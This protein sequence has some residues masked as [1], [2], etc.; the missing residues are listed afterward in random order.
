VRVVTG[1]PPLPMNPAGAVPIGAAAAL[2]EGPAGGQVFVHGVLT[3]VWAPGDQAGRSLAAVQLVATGAAS[4]VEV[5]VAFDVS[6]E[7]LRR[8]ALAVS[9]AGIAALVPAKRGPKG[10]SKLTDQLVARIQGLRRD[11]A[12][13]VAIADQ[14]GVST[15]T[16]RRAI[17]APPAPVTEGGQA[18]P[19]TVGQPTVD[20][21][22]V[23]PVL[24]APAPRSVERAAAWAGWLT[25]A[26]P[27]FTACSR[28][29]LAGLFLAFPGVETTGLLDCATRVYGALPDGFYGLESMLVEGVL[30]NLVGEPRAEGASRIN[31]VDLGRV[32]GL[33]R[34]PEVKTIRRRIGQLA[35][36][37]LSADLQQAIAAHHLQTY[38]PEDQVGV[39]LYVDGHVRAYCG[40][41]AI[42]KTHAPRLKFPAPATVET[43][44]CDGAGDPVLVVMAEPSASLAGELRRLLPALREAVGDDRRVLVGFDRGGWS[45]A[46][47]EHMHTAGF[48]VLTW[49][50]GAT[51]DIAGHLFTTVTHTDP[52]TGITGTWTAAD[53]TVD[54]PINDTHRVLPMRQITKLSATRDGVRQAH[55][56]TTRTD[57]PTGEVIHRMGARW[58]VEN[59]FRYARQHFDLDSHDSY[60]ATDDDPGRLVPN[61]TRRKAHARLVAARDVVQV[62]QA[63]A[64]TALL[65]LHNPT[66][67]HPITIT[68]AEHDRVTTRLRD[69]EDHLARL[70]A[71]YRQI[72]AR[73]PLGQ[74][75]P[76]QKILETQTK[77]ITHAIAMTAYNTITALAR[78]I[79]INTGYTRA[80]D[81][82]HNLARIALKATGDIQPG[83]GTLTI[84]LDPLPTTRATEAISELCAHLTATHTRY[85]GTDLVMHYKIKN[86]NTPHKN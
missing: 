41:R 15:D 19:V 13:L 76:A 11:S 38:R 14:T 65:D 72:P 6:P 80:T 42:G 85:P 59:Y 79:R 56:L 73:L 57:L 69:A 82:A 84:T 28:V 35:D 77:L 58:R 63:R 81:E 50:K 45:P 70:E 71:D 18:G 1:Q 75:N 52:D 64:D 31:P 32:L 61:P 33:D 34:A 9:Q 2:L 49:R 21:D 48:D 39:V 54:V 22:Q 17:A 27:V 25:Q 30:R 8:R 12:T 78:D 60:H 23:L 46:L 83:P 86:T 62:E 3:A 16:V 66:P 51:P 53:T 20:P 26:P 37:G 36:R 10:P 47:F 40:T 5:A 4:Q 74:V 43:W 29:P 7:T 24:A 44:I 55:I 67:G 68:N